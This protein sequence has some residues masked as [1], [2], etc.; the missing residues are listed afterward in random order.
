M[1][2]TCMNSVKIGGKLHKPG[3]VISVNNDDAKRLID[4]G[5]AVK[6]GKGSAAL[7]TPPQENVPSWDYKS[8]PEATAAL[9]EMHSKEEIN[10][11]IAGEKRKGIIKAA[12]KRMNALK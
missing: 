8:I 6:G 1:E 11:F 3:S 10:I 7:P 9:N 5:A 4:K 12:K 2:I